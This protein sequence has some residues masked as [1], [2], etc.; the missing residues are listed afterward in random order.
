MINKPNQ[1]ISLL[2]K[3]ENYH[4]VALMAFCITAPWSLALAQITYGFAILFSLS[5]IF[6]K[7]VP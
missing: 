7:K 4:F 5:F 6:V 3:I 2:D 1:N